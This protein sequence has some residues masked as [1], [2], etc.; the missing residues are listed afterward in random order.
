MITRL[1]VGNIAAYG[2]HLYTQLMSR[3]SRVAEKG[4]FTE[5][6]GVI[7]A[8]DTYPMDLNQCLTQSRLFRFLKIDRFKSFWFS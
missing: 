8:A 6:T 2:K 7:C 5:I 3:N 1:D 4:H